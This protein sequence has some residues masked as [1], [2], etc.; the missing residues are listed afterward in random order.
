MEDKTEKIT[1]WVCASEDLKLERESQI[2]GNLGSDNFLITNSDYGRTAAIYQCANCGFMQCPHLTE[3]LAFYENMEDDQYEE[4]REQRLLQERK[5]MQ[6]IQ[7]VKPGGKLLDV[8]AGS[9]ILIE[10]AQELGYE[11]EG[12]EPSKWLHAKAQSL[13]L[14]VEL[15]IFPQEDKL[16]GPY[17]IVTLVDVIEHVSDPGG[18]VSEIRKVMKD[19]GILIVVTPDVKS[20]M[21]RVLKYKWWHFRI[22]HIGY[23]NKKNLNLLMDRAGFNV[24]RMIRP[25]WFFSMEYLL[26]RVSTYLPGKMSVPAPGFIKRMV[27]PVNLRDSWMGIYK[28]KA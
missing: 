5:V 23:F 21:A 8:G 24:H 22:A 10:A 27:V 6:Q 4:G 7:K 20:T 18:L 2:D 9:G 13:N 14:P 12:V 19:D 26:E 17:D 28:K 11:A 15:G 16:R 1:C 25:T 3:V